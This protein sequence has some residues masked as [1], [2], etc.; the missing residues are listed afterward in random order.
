MREVCVQAGF[1]NKLRPAHITAWVKCVCVCV[2]VE[3]AW[4][5]IVDAPA[6]ITEK[7]AAEA[8][9]D[10]HADSLLVACRLELAG[11]GL[12]DAA[13]L[14]FHQPANGFFFLLAKAILFGPEAR[15]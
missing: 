9:G 6:Q 5:C 11:L 4:T 3:A 13:T 2:T 12:A 8:V 10:S 7:H 14:S 1:E 15:A